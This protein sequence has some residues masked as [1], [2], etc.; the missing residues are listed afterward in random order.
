MRIYKTIYKANAQTE[1]IKQ[2]NVKVKINQN[3]YS[4]SKFGT[5]INDFA[6]RV[7]ILLL[8]KSLKW[9]EKKYSEIIISEKNKSK[10]S[11]KRQ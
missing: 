5:E 4:S 2:N 7:V 3:T 8:P 6:G 11:Q 9:E 1:T 10:V